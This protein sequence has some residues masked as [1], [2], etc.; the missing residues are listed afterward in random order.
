MRDRRKHVYV[1]GQCRLQNDLLVD[2]LADKTGIACCVEDHISNFLKKK[3]GHSDQ[4]KLILYDC[5]GMSTET[6]LAEL[7]SLSEAGGT[8]FFL[9][10]FNVK[11]EL[12]IEQEALGFGVRGIFYENDSVACIVK[13]VEAIFTGEFWISRKVMVECL[14]SVDH[15]LSHD[16]KDPQL[17]TPR[18][19][20]ILRHVAMGTTNEVIG[21][22][23]CISPHT[24]RTHIYNIFKKINVPNRLQ[25]SL[26]AAK[27]L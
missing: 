7:T 14:L 24:V 16:K 10:L 13:G 21:D 19:E 27:H 23:L 1:I 18:E 15:P 6:L 26:W 4:Q 3:E 17:L 20:E 9:A 2:H 8:Q 25:A 11:P 5:L 22:E 12:H